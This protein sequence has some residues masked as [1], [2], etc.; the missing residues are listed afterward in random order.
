MKLL[1]Y[2]ED[3]NQTNFV[4]VKTLPATSATDDPVVTLAGNVFVIDIMDQS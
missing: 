3:T 4:T 2:Y 1:Y